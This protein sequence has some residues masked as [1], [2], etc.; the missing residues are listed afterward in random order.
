MRVS[1]I[2]WSK[3]FI[4]V[5]PTHKYMYTS[6]T[7][8]LQ[9][10]LLGPLGMHYQFSHFNNRGQWYSKVTNKIFTV[11]SSA[12]TNSGAVIKSGRQLIQSLRYFIFLKSYCNLDL[13][14]NK[15]QQS[16][17]YFRIP[18]VVFCMLENLNKLCKVKN[19]FLPLEF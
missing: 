19:D 3:L 4:V 15:V 6:S 1:A 10:C 5:L 8:T 13:H 9:L 11:L 16:S 14:L 18:L 12:V 2:Q 17:I 7:T